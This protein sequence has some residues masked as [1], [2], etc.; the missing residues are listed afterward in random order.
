VICSA[1][2]DR[3]ISAPGCGYWIRMVWNKLGADVDLWFHPPAATGWTAVGWSSRTPNWGNQATAADDPI[4]YEDCITT[5]TAE[6]IT[7][8]SLATPGTYRVRAHYYSDRGKGP[9]T[10]II[11]VFQGQT[12]LF[13]GSRV[14]AA[15]GNEWFAFD[16]VVP[17]PAKPDSAPRVVVD[18]RVVMRPPGYHGVK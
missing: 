6:E 11:E 5:C 7:V 15:S 12:R 13:A 1:F 17:T 9:S 10:V 8:S 2:V 18:D 16:I 3:G 4:L 14:L